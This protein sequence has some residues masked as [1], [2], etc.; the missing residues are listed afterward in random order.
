MRRAID[1]DEPHHL[2]EG[3]YHSL[4]DRIGTLEQAI[5]LIVRRKK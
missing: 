1:P 3:E 2:T 5:E 4:L